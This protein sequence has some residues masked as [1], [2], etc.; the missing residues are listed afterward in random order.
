MKS[1][2]A[3][4][5][6]LAVSAL[7]SG[8]WPTPAPAR[9]PA[10]P[11]PV[12]R[13]ATRP[14]AAPAP[15][16]RARNIILMISDGAGFNAFK[17]ASYF[18]HGRLGR[19]PYD[20][21]DVKLA[22]STF[23]LNY[24]DRQGRELLAPDDGSVPEVAEGLA[25]QQYVP[26]RVWNAFHATRGQSNYLRYT[27]SAAAATAI[28]TGQKTTKLR[29][30]TD[31]WG[32]K[33]LR[34]IGQQAKDRGLSVGVVTSV[35]FAHATPA[36]LF[37]HNPLRNNYAHIAREMIT[38]SGLDVIL[39]CGNPDYDH[40]GRPVADPPAE[41]YKYVGGR[42]LW[43]QLKA[44]KSPA[45]WKLIESRLEFEAL[46]MRPDLAPRKLIGV[47]R[48]HKTLQFER[49]PMQDWN[50]DGRVHT[51]GDSP[52]WDGRFAEV[53]TGKPG[54]GDPFVADV[55]SLSVMTLAALNTLARNDQGLLLVVEGGAVDWANH[56]NA[57]GRMIEEQMDFNAAVEA[58]VRWVDDPATEADWSD[59]LLIVTSDHECGQLW[60]PSAGPPR[61]PADPPSFAE[62]VNR[63]RGRMPEAKYFSGGHTN[64][65]VPLYAHGAG[66]EVFQQITREHATR[67]DPV[68]G[69][70]V[71]NTDIY[72]VMHQA[73]TGR[74]ENA[75][76]D[77]TADR[78]A[79]DERTAR[80]AHAA[81]IGE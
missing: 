15:R 49:S 6:S 44:G 17:C 68:Y 23:M 3:L 73:L 69:P 29:I 46:A 31:G 25:G 43:K 55:P 16:V 62:P 48:V 77:A 13:V 9:L 71:D 5:A 30:S 60:H 76:A 2:S 41:R 12:R 78:A 63:G 35:Q 61:R 52:R 27:G 58:V 19:Q 70:Y 64:A 21:F 20:A 11:Q 80:R 81:G 56:A 22:C 50:A 24:V 39:G 37:A 36:A 65:L 28:Y 10:S 67:K 75:E 51:D 72:R 74:R 54:R 32:R 53:N 7:L 40:N 59:T 38:R 34:T 26:S 4:L 57:L 8:L 47:P 14:A 66:A 45:G 79:G 18:E 42:E 33:P 1:N